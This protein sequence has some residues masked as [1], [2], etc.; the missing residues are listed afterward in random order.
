MKRI[1]WIFISLLIV[2]TGC[3]SSKITTSWK[4]ENIEPKQYNK[5][6]VLG[7]INE[8]DRLVREKMEEHV[9][10]DLKALGYTAVCS[11][12]EFNPK[13]FENMTEKQALDMLDK[14]GID[15]VLTVVL[16]DKTKSSITFPARFIILRII[17]T[18]TGFM[19]TIEP[20]TAGFIP[21]LLRG[22]HKIFLGK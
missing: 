11:C 13:A 2:I 8:P 15:A 16:L 22:E 21:R 9:V 5:I 7:L 6:L 17:F 3:T 18:R 14:S 19:D 12:D 20:C 4:A 1:K 10:A